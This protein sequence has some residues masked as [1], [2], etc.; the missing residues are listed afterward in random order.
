MDGRRESTVHHTSRVVNVDEFCTP[1]CKRV[2]RRNKGLQVEL[3]L[4]GMRKFATCFL[5]NAMVNPGLKASE[6]TNKARRGR[7]VCEG[8]N[9]HFSKSF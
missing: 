9:M 4:K 8:K 3:L 6:L 1:R 2:M 5:P 7:F